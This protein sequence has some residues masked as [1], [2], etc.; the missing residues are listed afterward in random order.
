MLTTKDPKFSIN[1]TSSI[2]NGKIPYFAKNAKE[3][4]GLKKEKKLDLMN[5]CAKHYEEKREN[6]YSVESALESALDRANEGL[7]FSSQAYT[8]IVE[9]FSK[10]VNLEIDNKIY[11][12]ICDIAYIK[13]TNQRAI[14][15]LKSRASN[16]YNIFTS[17]DESNNWFNSDCENIRRFLQ[18]Y[19]INIIKLK[20]PKENG[21]E[22]IEDYYEKIEYALKLLEA[23]L[24]L[25]I[26]ELQEKTNSLRNLNDVRNLARLENMI[27]ISN[28][29]KEKERGIL[30]LSESLRG[31][32]EMENLGLEGCVRKYLELVEYF[33]KKKTIIERLREK[34]AA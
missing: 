12:R 16:Y 4:D 17:I 28:V 5:F 31:K 18:E 14:R 33:T 6:A 21:F 1:L 3:I 23:P 34:F 29:H 25:N 9:K 8:K 30:G 11:E 27:K 26:K 10:K 19:A 7:I 32:K 20:I 15:T 2:D 22:K 24:L 13:G